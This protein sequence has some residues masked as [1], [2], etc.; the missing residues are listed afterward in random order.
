MRNNKNSKKV[1]T[2][3]KAIKD[4]KKLLKDNKKQICIYIYDIYIYQHTYI[5]IIN[6]KKHKKNITN[7]KNQ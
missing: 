4:N 7:Y 1:D 2:Y 6:N 3:K 5:S